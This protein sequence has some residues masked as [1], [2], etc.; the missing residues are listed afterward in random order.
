V[1]PLVRLDLSSLSLAG[2]MGLI[3]F[4][5]MGIGAFIRAP[6]MGSVCD[7]AMGLYLGDVVALLAS[8]VPPSWT[9]RGPAALDMVRARPFAEAA[10]VGWPSCLASGP[11]SL[12]DFDL[13][14]IPH[15]RGLDF[16]E[17]SLLGGW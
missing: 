10:L 7:L 13:P 16:D 8:W 6:I 1:F 4:R 2:G 3:A 9:E 17:S 5:G 14:N 11:F 15:F 12:L